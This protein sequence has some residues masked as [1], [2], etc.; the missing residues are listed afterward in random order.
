MGEPI[1]GHGS[2]VPD[3]TPHW[4]FRVGSGLHFPCHAEWSPIGQHAVELAAFLFG[5]D[6]YWAY[7]ERQTRQNAKVSKA[8]S[9]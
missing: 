3:L 5:G 1:C 4:P 8:C 9:M 7:G 2:C 6:L